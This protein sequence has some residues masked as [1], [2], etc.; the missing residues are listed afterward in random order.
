MTS[1]STQLHI[2]DQWREIAAVVDRYEDAVGQKLPDV[3][4][5]LGGVSESNRA[6]ALV[7]LLQ[8]EQEHRWRRGEGKTVEEYVAEYPELLAQHDAVRQLARWEC[9]LRCRT[10]DRDF[11]KGFSRRFPDLD[12]ECDTLCDAASAT[13]SRMGRC[14]SCPVV[15]PRQIGRYLVEARIGGGAFG[16]VYRCRDPELDRLVAIKLTRDSTSSAAAFLHEAK[17][18]AG[19]AHPNIVGLLDHGRLDDGRPYIVYEYVAGRTLADRIAAGD[20]TLGEAIRWTIA[21]AGALQAAHRQRIYHRDLKPAN[22]LVDEEGRVRLTDF[23]MARRD[24][25]FYADDRGTQLGTPSYMSPEQASFRSEWA[26]PASDIYSLGVVLYEL[27][28]GRVPFRDT[29]L[30]SLLAQIRERPPVAPR[31]LDGRIPGRV[32]EACL[33]ALEKDPAKRFRTAGDFARALRTAVEPR[34][35]RAW[36]VVA[37]AA[38]LCAL[39]LFFLGPHA[40]DLKRDRPKISIRD[41]AVG[42]DVAPGCLPHSGDKLRIHSWLSQGEGYLYVI[43]FTS[44]GKAQ[45]KG[46]DEPGIQLQYDVTVAPGRGVMAVLVVGRNEPLTHEALDKLV[47]AEFRWPPPPRKIG[48]DFQLPS[49]PRT[50]MSDLTPGVTRGEVFDFPESFVKKMDSLFGRDYSAVLIPCLDQPATSAPK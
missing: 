38:G 50:P 8:V 17:N 34:S 29:E 14:K 4:E 28:C 23:G 18:V 35:R 32:E 19:L 13:P 40:P 27:L 46:S 30:K 7:E 21:L 1:N 39:G 12:L 41:D 16:V 43:V 31:S 26:G 5:L 25:L 48:T 47:A 10:G 45:V 24:D 2:T 49:I 20:Y 33:R 6:V 22:V 36:L 3:R 11:R 9:R 37:A 15:R 42:R 44:G